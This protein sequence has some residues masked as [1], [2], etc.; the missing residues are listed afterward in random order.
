M[1][2][3]EPCEDLAE[4]EVEGIVEGDATVL[5]IAGLATAGLIGVAALF[6]FKK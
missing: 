1:D 3:Y 2:V 4:V 5:I 6:L